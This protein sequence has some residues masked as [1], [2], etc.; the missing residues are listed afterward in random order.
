VQVQKSL[1]H[2][3]RV[4]LCRWHPDGRTLATTADDRLIRLWDVPSGVP[5][6][7]LVGHAT[8]GLRCTFDS[9]GAKLL[10]NDWDNNLRLWEPSSG[11]QSLS[12]P[13]SGYYHLHVSPDDNLVI[14]PVAAPT[15]LQLLRLHGNSEYR[16]IAIGATNGRVATVHPAGRLLAVGLPNDHTIALVDLATA[17]L[18]G[19]LRI[20]RGGPLWWESPESLLTFGQSGLLR[21][22]VKIDPRE[23]DHYRFGP[24]RRIQAASPGQQSAIS[25]DL[26]TIAIE[27][28]YQGVV[29]L[30]G[31]HGQKTVTLKPKQDVRFCAVSPDGKWIATG[32]HSHS[33]GLEA[34]VW[35]GA[36]GGLVKE[37]PVSELC[38]VTFSPDGRWLLTT[39]GGCRLWAVGTWAEGPTLGGQNGCFSA[40]SRLLA[41]EGSQGVIRLVEPDTGVELARLESPEQSRLV[42]VCFTPDGTGLIAA[43]V[44]TQAL[45]IWDLRL[46]RQELAPLGLDWK[47]PPYSPIMPLASFSGPGSKP[48]A[49]GPPLQVTIDLGEFKTPATSEPDPGLPFNNEAW[50]LVASD[51]ERAIE[52]AQKA[53]QLAPNK[54]F[55][56]NTLGVAHYRARHWKPALLALN[57]SMDL[58]NGELESFN[59]FFLA[60]TY[61]R[62]GDE[63]KARELYDQAVRWIEK[64]QSVLE[65]QPSNQKELRRFRAEAADLLGLKDTSETQ[66]K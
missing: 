39:G 4:E 48:V 65:K 53:V 30:H 56:W 2:P 9:S 29:V 37:L 28:S 8:L 21:W 24:P 27:K 22:P 7:E 10:S 46:L 19:N 12:L 13:G 40:D 44:D 14:E 6:R 52:L 54:G 50:S 60:M 32:S 62:L 15:T 34:K 38:F 3:L 20:G 11:R 26:Q 66:P 63:E 35:E 23:P 49:A 41:V 55:Y 61:W 64:N 36:T 58:M 33:D 31:A 45:H 17:R 16:T 5:T 43:G 57:K 1:D 59:T 18:V 51:A 25:A 42:P 47:A